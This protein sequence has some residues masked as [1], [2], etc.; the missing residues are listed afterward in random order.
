MKD[1]FNVIG[2]LI[3]VPIIITVGYF[4][5]GT[6]LYF[7]PFLLAVGVILLVLFLIFD[8][9]TG[10]N[11]N[12]M[13]TLPI[14]RTVDELAELLCTDVRLLYAISNKTPVWYKCFQ[15]P[16]NN[17][18]M[19]NIEAPRPYL[20]KIQRRIQ[21][22]ILSCFVVHDCAT[23]FLP[24]KNIRR[25]A[26]FHVNKPVVLNCDIKNF[27]PSLK[28]RSVFEFFRN[29][30]GYEPDI[31]M[32]LSRLCTLYGHLP[33]G[34][35]TSPMLSNLLMFEADKTI[36]QWAAKHYL[37]YSRYADDLT[38][39]GDID[40]RLQA[41]IL[42][43]V[44]HNL[45]LLH[46]KLNPAKTK[47]YR[48]NRRQL[49]TGLVVNEYVGVPREKIREFRTWLHYTEV[50]IKNG[51][52]YYDDE[53]FASRLGLLNFYCSVNTSEKLWQWREWLLEIKKKYS[54]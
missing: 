52:F 46:L 6:F 15:I 1:A 38:F 30:T 25:N 19:R 26:L 29:N 4:I 18:S 5:I 44:K 50:D 35:P 53:E 22:K 8:N 12:F 42:R 47:L 34:A 40:D 9:M 49:V 17:G 11:I 48:N 54:A 21:K 23:A 45:T 51:N 28:S 31:C 39:S 32:M 14:I 3:A 2:C 20:K 36:C 13:E 7:I 10:F 27:F 33:Q 16:K 37:S 43:M 24:G 41:D